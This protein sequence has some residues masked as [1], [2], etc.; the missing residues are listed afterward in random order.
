MYALPDIYA[1]E[2]PTISSSS[3]LT[4]YYIFEHADYGQDDITMSNISII[5]IN[6]DIN[7]IL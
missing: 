4:T 2:L 1:D 5:D 6:N 3:Y 7:D